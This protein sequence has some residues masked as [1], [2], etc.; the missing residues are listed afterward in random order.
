ME[1]TCHFLESTAHRARR[2]ACATRCFSRLRS[3]F[4]RAVATTF[5]IFPQR[6]PT[7]SPASTRSATNSPV[8]AHLAARHLNKMWHGGLRQVLLYCFRLGNCGT[9]MP[10]SSARA[11]SRIAAVW[12]WFVAVFPAF[13]IG[14][15]PFPVH[16]RNP[17]GDHLGVVRRVV[18][19]PLKSA[20][21]GN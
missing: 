18:L 13:S 17:F 19:G 9:F 6:S 4:L 21:A 3:H 16:R 14:P 10:L 12:T 11:E 15:L 20:A 2:F 1:E 8:E 7:G 5:G